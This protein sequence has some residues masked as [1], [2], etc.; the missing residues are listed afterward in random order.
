MA[1]IA[2]FGTVQSGHAVEK[3]TLSNADLRVG[4]LTYGAILQSFSSSVFLLRCHL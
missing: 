4:I 3:I 1:Q 2:P